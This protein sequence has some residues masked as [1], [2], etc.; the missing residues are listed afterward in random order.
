MPG[1]RGRDDTHAMHKILQLG[2]IFS[3]IVL[4]AF[5]IGAIATGI[6]GKSTVQ[7]NLKQEQFAMQL[8]NQF[9]SIFKR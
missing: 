6:D 3:A 5:G 7:D 9:D 2:G 8:I 4:I 1:L